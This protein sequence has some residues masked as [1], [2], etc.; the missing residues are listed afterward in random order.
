MKVLLSELRNHGNVRSF[1]A[2]ISLRSNVILLLIN[3]CSTVGQVVTKLPR[4]FSDS[5]KQGAGMA[6]EWSER[7]LTGLSNPSPDL[8][9]SLST[10]KF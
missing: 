7:V 10:G 3:G 6:V 5:I 4:R 8:F 2:L 1:K 9:H